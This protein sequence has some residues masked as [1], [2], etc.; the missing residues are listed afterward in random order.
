MVSRLKSASPLR[1][2]IL[3]TVGLLV[4]A[5]TAWCQ[6]S[7][8][9]PLRPNPDARPETV[10]AEEHKQSIRV[11]VNEVTA[12]VAVRDHAGEMVFD[13]TE[14]DFHI[15]DNGVEQKIEHFDLGG[16]PL[17]ILL[18]VETSS[19]IEALL[20]AV[21]R[22]GIVFS[23]TVMGQ[24]AEAGIVGFD[25]SVDLLEGFTTDVDRVRETI[26]RLRM[27]TS[28]RRL[29]DAMSR[30]VQLLEERPPV[31]R[32]ILVVVGE[33]QDR[34]SESKLGEVLRQAQLANVTIYSMG[35]S[36][37]A[38]ELRAPAN[39]AQP[40]QIGPPG[41]YP[42][43][44]PNGKPQT[45]QLEQEV[46]GNMD[47]LA[48]AEWLVETGRNALGPNSLAV[49]SKAT[50]G[51]HLNT[52]KDRSIERAMDEIGGELHAEYTLGYRPTDPESYGYHEIKV[53]VIRPGVS[54]RTRP[55][56]YLAPP[57]S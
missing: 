42:V 26:E 22:A 46:Q 23:E 31:R 32:R 44:T 21:R 11:R 45:P 49:A 27:G 53:Q 43:P 18:V 37:T 14:N 1:L 9:G 13:L 40:P 10:P 8:P 30:G 38:A 20:G 2:F 47:L 16:D 55:G 51:L 34:G 12:P 25:D 19:H 39:Q 41:T 50:G 57:P 24:T 35:L 36:T 15:Y 52:L 4:F 29:Y 54:V 33:A 7:P 56:Y 17:S 6:G 3:L 28:G 5:R 48:L